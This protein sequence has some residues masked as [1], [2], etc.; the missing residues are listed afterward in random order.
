MILDFEKNIFFINGKVINDQQNFDINKLKHICKL[1]FPNYNNDICKFIDDF[2]SFYNEGKSEYDYTIDI[3]HIAFWL[4]V[5]KEHLKRLLE[6]NFVKNQDYIETT[7]QMIPDRWF[8]A[9]S[10]MI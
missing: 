6:S 4:D 10:K 7:N 9:Q 2:Y 1:H 3:E 5:K 8:K